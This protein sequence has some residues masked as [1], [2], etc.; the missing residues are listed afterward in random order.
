VQG[1]ISWLGA[2]TN[3]TLIY[4]FRPSTVLQH[5]TPNPH[6]PTHGSPHLVSIIDSYASSHTA[7]AVLPTL[8]PLALLA[9][10][11]SHGYIILRWAVEAIAE[12]VLWRGSQ[13]EVEVQKMM[14]KG[15][16]GVEARLRELGERK[17]GSEGL[18]GGFWNGGEEGGREI[19]RVGKAE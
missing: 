11:A 17:Y 14:A 4:L 6:V 18:R 1:I 9:L 7:R 12:R 13:E 2:V 19:G 16:G 15:Q 5:Q 3:A 10:A 8:I